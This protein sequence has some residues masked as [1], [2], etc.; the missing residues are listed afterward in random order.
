MKVL[1]TGGA[2]YIGSTIA[3]ACADEGITPVIL[4]NFATGRREYL[5]HRAAYQGDIADGALLDQIF[6]E[7]PDL[8]AVIHCAALST[9]P[10]S[11]ANPILYYRENL[12]ATISLTEYLLRNGC[13]R[14]LFASSAAVYGT[15]ATTVTETDRLNPA[16]PYART[17]ASCEAFLKDT[18]AATGL[19]VIAMRYANP[20]GTDPLLRTG[21]QV[22][23]PTHLLGRLISAAEDGAPFTLTGTDWPTRDGSGLRDFIHVWDLATAHVRALRSFDTVTADAPFRALNISSGAGTTVRELAHAFQS[24]TRQTVDLKEAPARPGDVAGF[25]MDNALAARLLGWSPRLT[26][27]EAIHHAMEWRPVRARLLM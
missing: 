2:G 24:A 11:T 15:T 6:T 18:S 19:A 23:R 26:V 25:T 9:V 17:K 20:I 7:H 16:S 22:D 8:Y 14:L 12:A 3:S 21:L 13:R 5:G 1:I 27:T 4:D 10:E